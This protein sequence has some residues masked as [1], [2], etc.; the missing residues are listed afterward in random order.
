MP[1]TSVSDIQKLQIFP[2]KHVPDSLLYYAPSQNDVYTKRQ[3]YPTKM[4]K[5]IKAYEMERFIGKK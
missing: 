1:K 4:Q 2:G 5:S 3:F